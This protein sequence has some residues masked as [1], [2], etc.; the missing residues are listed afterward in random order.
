MQLLV[1][2]FRE[3]GVMMY[4]ILAVGLVATSLAIA[5]FAVPSTSLRL[6]ALVIAFAPLGLGLLGTA[7]GRRQVERAVAGADVSTQ[8]QLQR[9]GYA[10]AMRPLQ[11][12]SA[13]TMLA[14]LPA[15]LAMTI[16]TTKPVS[17]S[18]R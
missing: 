1:T 3:G 14:A 4:V 15:L 10:E 6:V 9:A 5:A 13:F 12:G 16:G 11:L 18:R 7:L 17:P 2:F 8:A